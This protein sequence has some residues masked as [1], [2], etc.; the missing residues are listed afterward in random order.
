M[1][2]PAS[3]PA[4]LRALITAS[5]ADSWYVETARPAPPPT[6]PLDG[7]ARCDVV[8]VGGGITGCSAALELAERGLSVRLLEARRVG[9]AASGRN[10]GQV[11]SGFGGGMSHAERHLPPA[12]VARVRALGTAA[13]HLLEARLARHRIA[14]DYQ[15]SGTLLLA[16]NPGH[17]RGLTALAEEMDRHGP[18]GHTLWEAEEARARGVNSRRV[19]GALHDPLGGHLQ[20]LDY[21]RGLARAAVEAGAVL[22]EDCP[23]LGFESAPSGPGRPAV[24]VHTP[25]GRLDADWLL[26]CGNAELWGQVPSLARATLPAGSAILAT[27]P[28][29]PLAKELMPGD[30]AVADMRRILSY[31][32]LSP[33][34][35]MLFG[36]RA[37]RAEVRHPAVA[38]R[39]RQTMIDYFPQLAEARISHVWGGNV[40]LTGDRFPEFGRLGPRVLFAHGYSGHGV[41]LAGLAGDLL[42]E[43]V[44]GDAT[45]FELLARLPHPR[46]PAWATPALPAIRATRPGVI[47]LAVLWLGLRDRLG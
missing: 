15:P 29:G 27:E 13:V 44:A 22:H 19:L 9:F 21:T 4:P 2:R 31:F 28:L 12:D 38:A 10:G 33:D 20:P 6:P 36:G 47:A 30:H 32:R 42:G 18:A 8:V 41:A 5:A 45:D 35:R 3:V 26:L 40:A 7:S 17:R 37:A 25:D 24:T 1:S 34:G 23:M 11:H 14:C 16:V 46:L 39:L 43:A